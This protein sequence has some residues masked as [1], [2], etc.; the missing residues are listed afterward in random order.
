VRLEFLGAAVL[1]SL[2]IPAPDD[3]NDGRWVWILQEWWLQRKSCPN[4]IFSTTNSTW[5]T[6]A[7]NP[8]SEVRIRCLTARV[9]T[10]P[11]RG[12]WHQ[13]PWGNLT[14][15]WKYFKQ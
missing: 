10:H 5:T 14:G 2:F 7:M 8:A 6:L 13:V 9:L 11:R 15:Q 3:M 12:L 1:N 4:P